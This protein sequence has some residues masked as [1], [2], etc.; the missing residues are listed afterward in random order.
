MEPVTTGRISDSLFLYCNEA[1]QSLFT[2]DNKFN[3][4]VGSETFLHFG[5]KTQTHLR[6]TPYIKNDHLDYALK[7]D[8]RA[9][10]LHFKLTS[11][12]GK[13]LS[14]HKDAP[15]LPFRNLFFTIYL[16]N[17]GMP[18]LHMVQSEQIVFLT[19]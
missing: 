14:Q 10:A 2:A 15:I 5:P 17:R 16:S 18:S 8:I 11:P 19:Q 4:C 3:S 7:D 6:M 1:L 13:T 12:T 9:S